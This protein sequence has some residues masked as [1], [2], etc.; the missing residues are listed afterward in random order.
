M[1]ENLSGENTFDRLSNVYQQERGTYLDKVS[2]VEP[3]ILTAISTNEF[4]RLLISPS[5]PR[6]IWI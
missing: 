2:D 1:T 6:H 4:Q 5:Y 3:L